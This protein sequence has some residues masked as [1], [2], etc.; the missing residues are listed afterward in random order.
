LKYPGIEI[1]VAGDYLLIVP[2]G[3]ERP[4]EIRVFM[5]VPEKV[6]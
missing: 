3:I 6:G 5:D 2:E 4:L 1:E